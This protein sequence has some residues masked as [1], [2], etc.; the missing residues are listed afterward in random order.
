MISAEAS[1]AVA[2][3]AET[4]LD[5]SD[6]LLGL[7][8]KERQITELLLEKPTQSELDLDTRLRDVAST[9]ESEHPDASVRVSCPDGLTIWATT[10]FGRALQELVTNAV[11][12]DDSPSPDVAVTVSRTDEAVRIDVAD[13]GPPIPEMERNVLTDELEQTPL[14]HGSGLGLWLVNV[15]V[16][17]S[18]GVLSVAENS[19][20]GNVVSIEL[21]Q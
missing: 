3:S 4:I 12:H 19:P 21:Q 11:V 6:Q 9:V 13:T 10:Q 18:G 14:Y 15:I 1:S 7:A 8:E 16:T 17:R 20:T 2:A 5:T